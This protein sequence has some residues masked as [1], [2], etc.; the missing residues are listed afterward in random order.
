M[1]S[2]VWVDLIFFLRN[3]AGSVPF[4]FTTNQKVLVQFIW[5]EP[6]LENDI[7]MNYQYVPSH[8]RKISHWYTSDMMLVKGIS[9]FDSIGSSGFIFLSFRTVRIW[10]IS[11]DDEL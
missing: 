1:I 11:G 7:R 8:A 10:N 6:D 5:E 4:H 2:S 3:S 9:I